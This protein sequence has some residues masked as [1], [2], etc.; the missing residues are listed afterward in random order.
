MR[1]DMQHLIG[2]T[3]YRVLRRYRQWVEAEDLRQEMW[4]WAYQQ[5]ADELEQ[6]P[7][8][9]LRRRLYD[10][11]DTYARREKATKSGYR[12]GDEVFYS[13][14][15]IRELLP[16][17]FDDESY[18]GGV[19]NDHE[20]VSRVRSAVAV[21]MEYETALADVRRALSVLGLG[22]D[23]DLYRAYVEGESSDLAEAEA[24][25]QLRRVQ[26]YLGGTKPRGGQS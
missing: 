14:R 2:T 1:A 16:A 9:L 3:A 11:G 12:A 15:V 8:G 19:V 7:A 24:R 4:A 6:I 5:K 17:A 21:G 13:Q 26:R 22:R 25:R 23:S 18:R 10:V 20:K